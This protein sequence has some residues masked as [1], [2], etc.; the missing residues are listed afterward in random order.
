MTNPSD[1]HLLDVTANDI[2]D[3]ASKTAGAEHMFPRIIEELVHASSKEVSFHH[4]HSGKENNWPGFDGVVR[5]VGVHDYIPQGKSIWEIG[6]NNEVAKK[7]N[8]DYQKRL[9]ECSA[10]ER[11]E[12]TFVFV[13]PRKWREKTAW[14][15]KKRKLQEWK[16]VRVYDATDLQTWLNENPTCKLHFAKQLGKQII[17]AGTLEEEGNVWAY[18]PQPHLPSYLFARDVE[19]NIDTF[20]KW[21]H[22]PAGRNLIVYAD[23]INEGMA[24]LKCLLEHEKFKREKALA[25]VIKHEDAIPPLMAQNVDFLPILSDVSVLSKCVHPERRLHMIMVRT[26]G[27]RM[28]ALSNDTVIELNLLNSECVRAFQREVNRADLKIDIE[29]LAQRMGYCRVLIRSSLLPYDAHPQWI[30][31]EKNIELLQS[32]AMLGSLSSGN[33]DSKRI[34]LDAQG[35]SEKDWRKYKNDL[36]AL[37]KE[38]ESPI[39]ILDLKNSPYQHGFVCGVHSPLV[40][41]HQIK[42]SFDKCLLEKLFAIYKAIFFSEKG[43]DRRRLKMHVLRTLLAYRIHEYDWDVE[44]GEYLKERTTQLIRSILNHISECPSSDNVD[45]LRIIAEM[46]PEE[47]L[48]WSETHIDVLPQIANVPH[49]SFDESLALLAVPSRYFWRAFNLMVELMSREPVSCRDLS[50]YLKLCFDFGLPQTNASMYERKRAFKMLM[51][52]QSTFAIQIVLDNVPALHYKHSIFPN[53]SAIMRVGDWQHKYDCRSVVIMDFVDFCVKSVIERLHDCT[54][55]VVAFIEVIP[56]LWGEY[57]ERAWELVKYS[58]NKG[59]LKEKFNICAALRA[60]LGIGIKKK[61]NP[62][63]VQSFQRVLEEFVQTNPMLYVLPYFAR[64]INSVI[65][66]RIEYKKSFAVHLRLGALVLKRVMK[67]GVNPIP[68][69][70]STPNTHLSVL[71]GCIALRFGEEYI[72]SCFRDYIEEDYPSGSVSQFRQGMLQL[73]KEEQLQKILLQLC[74]KL[75][76]KEKLELIRC[77]PMCR[78]TWGVVHQHTDIEKQYWTDAR[79]L[80]LSYYDEETREY[81]VTELLRVGNYRAILESMDDFECECPKIALRVLRALSVERRGYALASMPTNALIRALSQLGEASV[82]YG[83]LAKLE[84]RFADILNG[85]QYHYPYISRMLA[86]KPQHVARWYKW[87]RRFRILRAD[88]PKG[89]C[90]WFLVKIRIPKYC[91]EAQVSLT[92]WCDAV[93]SEDSDDMESLQFFVGSALM[94]DS[95]RNLKTWLSPE[96][97]QCAEMFNSSRFDDGFALAL[98][99][100][101]GVTTRR[102]DDGGVV[103]RQFIQYISETMEDLQITDSH[104]GVILKDVSESLGNHGKMHDIQTW[105]QRHMW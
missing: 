72:L 37:A 36:F 5:H 43:N 100:S 50:R 39:W 67:L 31:N 18:A 2:A 96:I 51:E 52:K 85:T 19:E 55:E 30:Q 74:E 59:S 44:E 26:K 40:A 16:D 79:D 13:S 104:M 81:A 14:V 15:E 71:G 45:C 21:V 101:I 82:G 33:E 95:L 86:E 90:Y 65:W 8:D 61:N 12:L 35:L 7:I 22:A 87:F 97:C 38:E 57:V 46:M 4:F 66:D 93:L 89:V 54:S 77:A 53:P 34:H 80:P 42:G 60:K 1:I 64:G 63:W 91:A 27:A 29:A 84:F 73:M 88:Y 75:T 20:A 105:W 92:D 58:F 49:S 83:E 103:E 76:S 94:A 10:E 11:A 56:S 17:G 3:W 102:H 41:L 70:L 69:L 25:V 9:E 48:R 98:R 78:A 24:Y 32:L 23:S 47:Y 99:N 28:D 62:E 6:I 68:Y